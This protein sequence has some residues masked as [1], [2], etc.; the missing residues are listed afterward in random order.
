MAVSDSKEKISYTTEY[1]DTPIK[2]VWQQS[3]S[4][5]KNIQKA[6][7]LEIGTYEGGSL[8]WAMEN[9][10]LNGSCRADVIDPFF[11]PRTREVFFRNIQAAGLLNRICV[12]E[13]KSREILPNLEQDTYDLIYIDG[14]HRYSSV[15]FDALNSWPLL[16][17]GGY[18]V[19]DDFYWGRWSLPSADR[20]EEAI[21]HFLRLSQ[22]AIHIC[23]KGWQVVLQ[24]R[25]NLEIDRNFWQE[26]GQMW[27]SNLILPPPM[28]KTLQ[29]WNN[30][31]WTSK[32]YR[33]IRRNKRYELMTVDAAPK[34]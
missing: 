8:L 11:L 28:S 13:Q 18:L 7:Y 24:K 5:L 33:Q 4:E 25:K 20:P 9:V 26:P 31:W 29:N 27:L 10:F 30:Y 19:F 23:H 17:V 22:N 1:I 6:R 2:F 12:Y 32:V 3:L 14:D 16:R 15:L 21:N 34:V